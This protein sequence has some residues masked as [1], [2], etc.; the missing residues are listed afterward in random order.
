MPDH[1]RTHRDACPH[2]PFF[3]VG[4]P[5]GLFL[6]HLALRPRLA[7]SWC[8]AEKNLELDHG[9]A[10]THGDAQLPCLRD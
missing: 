3:P 6:P 10:M 8:T 4:P 9:M 5:P 7:V 1:R 2:P